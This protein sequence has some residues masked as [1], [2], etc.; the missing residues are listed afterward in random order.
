MPFCYRGPSETN[1]AELADH[2]G[3]AEY[4]QIHKSTT[5]FTLRTKPCSTLFGLH[6]LLCGDVTNAAD[7][8]RLMAGIADMIFC[9]PA[10]QR[11]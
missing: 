9:N 7:T 5:I 2:H 6:R 3:S 8:E 11:C 1:A 10:I 4:Q